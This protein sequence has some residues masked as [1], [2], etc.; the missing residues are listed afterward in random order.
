MRVREGKGREGKGKL[1]TFRWYLSV[2]TA[3]V[4]PG[5][6][7]VRANELSRSLPPLHF[8]ISASEGKAEF[9]SCLVNER[10]GEW[11]K[12]QKYRPLTE[13]H[14]SNPGLL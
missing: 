3:S 12:D 14:A 13:I 7:L 9:L 10:G 11:R 2:P 1:G 5:A 6:A 8:F 4:G